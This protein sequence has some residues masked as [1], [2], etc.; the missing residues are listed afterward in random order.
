MFLQGKWNMTIGP[1]L[2]IAYSC[3]NSNS[4]MPTSSYRYWLGI[5]SSWRT[6]NWN[7]IPQ[8]MPNTCH[9]TNNIQN[10]IGCMPSKRQFKNI[11]ED[12]SRIVHY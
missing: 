7:M 12:K 3:K 9:P 10:C 11:Q 8:D 4:L 5:E 6:C 1:P 2:S